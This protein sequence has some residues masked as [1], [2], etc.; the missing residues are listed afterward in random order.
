MIGTDIPNY[1]KEY[2][3]KYS[4][5]TFDFLME[6]MLGEIPDKFDKREGSIIWDALAPA[7]LELENLYIEL[8]Y[9]RKNTFAS[10]ADREHLIERAKE[11]G[12]YVLPATFSTVKAKFN[13]QIDVYTRFN[14]ERLNFFVEEYLGEQE[15]TDKPNTY[16]YKLRCENLGTIGNVES[17]KLTPIDNIQGLTIAEIISLLIPA[18]DEEDTEDFRTRYFESLYLTPYGG[19]VDDYILKVKELAEIGAVK[20]EPVWQGGGTVKL[21]ILDNK[22][23]TPSK[24]LIDEVQE[25]IDPIPYK[26][27]GKGIAPI[28]HIVTVLGATKVEINIDTKITFDKETVFKDVKSAIEKTIE[29][30]INELIK[31][32]QNKE[33][34]VVRLSQIE[35]RLLNIPGVLDIENTTINGKE[36]NLIL[37]ETEIPAMGVVTNG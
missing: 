24:E 4:E 30:Y 8:D 28:G 18:R 11:R 33:Y 29:E 32:W 13:K 15:E 9:I 20:V 37:K 36:E 14:F 21:T 31:Q 10:T 23:E 26:G 1:L 3:Y 22:L 2:D 16:L 34:L 35:A 27:L 25:K 6:R 7:A 19:N 12:K 5:M 17:G